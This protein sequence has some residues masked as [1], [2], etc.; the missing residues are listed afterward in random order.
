M[1]Y[2]SMRMKKHRVATPIYRES[3]YQR[4]LSPLSRTEVVLWASAVLLLLITLGVILLAR[5]DSGWVERYYSLGFYPIWAGVLGSLTGRLHFSLA[6]WVIIVFGLVC[7]VAAVVAVR[8]FVRGS[9]NRGRLLARFF[10]RALSVGTVILLLFTMGGGLNYYRQSF[11]EYSGL[12]VRPSEVAQLGALCAE[13]AGE[14]NA[15]RG[16]LNEDSAG[17]STFAPDTALG[18]STKANDSYS[19]LTA[20]YPQWKQL[21]S[22]AE[23]VPP[24]PVL[25]SEAMS[26]MQIVGFFFPYTIEANVNVHTTDYD[27]PNAMCHELAHIAGFMREDEANF[28]SYLACRESDDPFFRY[29]GTMLAF[30][31]SSN[32]LY[33]YSTDLHRQ[34][35]QSL[36]PAVLLDMQADAAYYDRYDTHFGDFSTNVN[37]T[38]LKVNNQQDGVAGYGR[39]VDLL[40]ADYRN[41]HNII[42]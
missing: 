36:S 32:A 12:T 9:G 26:Y 30:I 29:S 13:L 18:L 31:H 21:L 28:I 33:G 1:W 39:M 23:R 8:A 38:Y 4:K 11:A 22:L 24:K 6:Q 5:L 2:C 34:V 15:L 27:I 40:L 35:M 41:R 19:A 20:R 16:E 42:T 7:I 10:M 17:V 14:A 3:G 25:F 37:D